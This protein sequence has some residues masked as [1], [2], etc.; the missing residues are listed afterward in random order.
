MWTNSETISLPN[1]LQAFHHTYSNG[2]KV[3][4][5]SMPTAPIAGYMRVVNAGSAM[6]DG[7][8]GK[9]V[10]HFIEHMSFRIGG[11]KFWEMER[12]G[13]EDNAMTTEDATSFYDF[14]S[15]EQLEKCIDL[16]AKRFLTKEV[17]GDKI[18]IEMMAVLNEEERGKEAVGTLFR[19]AQAASHMY[20]RYHYPTIGMR[21][22]IINTSAEDMKKFREE[23]YKINNSTFIVVG[24]ICTQDVLNIFEEKYGHLDTPTPVEHNFPQEPIQLGKRTHEIHMNGAPCAMICVTWRSPAADM[25]DSIVLSVIAKIISNGSAGRKLNLLNKNIIHNVGVYSP[26]NVDDYIWCIHGAFGRPDKVTHGE[27]ALIHMVKQLKT[28]NDYELQTAIQTL[29]DEWGVEPFKNIQ[30][31]TMALGEACALMNW[32]DISQRLETL[33]TVSVADVK[34]VVAFYLT[35]HKATVVKVFPSKSL[36]FEDYEAEKMSEAVTSK[37]DKVDQVKPDLKWSAASVVQQ[38]GGFTIQSLATSGSEIII[39]LTLPM[40]E[41]QHWDASLLKGLFGKQCTFKNQHYY[42]NTI[43]NKATALGLAFSTEKGHDTF[44]ISFQ[45][46]KPDKF[47]EACDFALNG[48]FSNSKFNSQA[49]D[50]TK[51]GII[52]ELGALKM[53]PKYKLKEELMT[54]LFTNT[55]YGEKLSEKISKMHKTSLSSLCNYYLHAVKNSPIVKCTFTY[56]NTISTHVI[57]SV[58]NMVQRASNH[59]KRG[60]ASQPTVKKWNMVENNPT[61]FKQMVMPGYGSCCVMMGQVT[62]IKQYSREGIALSMAV[63]AL[64][65]GMTGRLMWQLRGQHGKENGVYGVYAIQEN[66]ENANTFVIVDATFT[67]GKCSQ[68]GITELRD[69]LNKWHKDGITP[70]ELENSKKELI[71]GRVLLM[72]D[73]D[74]VSD[75]F[76]RHLVN[77]KCPGE[78]WDNYLKNVRDIKLEEVTA[79]MSKLSAAKWSTVATTPTEIPDIVSHINNSYVDSD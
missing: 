27:E 65:G 35:E 22:D 18:P 23:Y 46:S 64:G 55:P 36:G 29:K 15:V 47:L 53:Q 42:A 72:D 37:I 50:S 32:K 70:E 74:S 43:K 1:N 33:K 69:V 38:K 7:I 26:R 78:E 28:V 61:D 14:G 40:T 24:H 30:S 73:F 34:R 77:N 4:T 56:P 8:C 3:I 67:P 6:E 58:A 9:G 16:D 68:H 25:K 48:L 10:A 2:M 19:T 21:S 66:Q 44:E 63:Q 12:N 75:V 41:F 76:H 49:F 57:S 79:A 60:L 20:S 5:V 71:G 13:H 39:N 17:P 62:D 59:S 11:G 31:T 54:R 51:N 45:M 52:A